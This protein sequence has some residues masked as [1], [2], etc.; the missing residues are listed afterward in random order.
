MTETNGDH[1]LEP[2][3]LISISRISKSKFLLQS[4][5]NRIKYSLSSLSLLSRF[6]PRKRRTQSDHVHSLPSTQYTFGSEADDGY[7]L[8][9]LRSFQKD[10]MSFVGSVAKVEIALIFEPPARSGSSQGRMPSLP[11]AVGT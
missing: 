1:W 2:Y 8:V 10:A 3:V 11:Q 9:R 4:A 7:N 6:Y 5:F